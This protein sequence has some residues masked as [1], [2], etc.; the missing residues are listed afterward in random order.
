MAS[1]KHKYIASYVLALRKRR[2]KQLSHSKYRNKYIE[3]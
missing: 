2:Y 3:I 1:L